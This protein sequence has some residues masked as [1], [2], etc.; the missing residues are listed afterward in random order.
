MR[1]DALGVGF[2]FDS[3][4]AAIA[5]LAEVDLAVASLG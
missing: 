3:E 5:G 4:R 1:A 2:A